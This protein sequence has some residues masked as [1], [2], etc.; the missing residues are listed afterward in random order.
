MDNP[1]DLYNSKIKRINIPLPE[2]K[3]YHR[4]SSDEKVD[5]KFIGRD[6][7]SRKLYSWLTD[8][9]TPSGSYLVTGYRGMGKSSFVGRILYELS[10]RVSSRQYWTGLFI[11]III[12][13]CL[14]LL[15]IGEDNRKVFSIFKL[16]ETDGDLWLII[17]FCIIIIVFIQNFNVVRSIFRTVSFAFRL[18]Y[19]LIWDKKFSVTQSMSFRKKIHN[20]SIVF[21][22]YF[23]DWPTLNRILHN[24]TLW[25]KT[26]RRICINV[27]LGQDTLRERE[28]LSIIAYELYK[29]YRA[30]M[31]SPIAN[32]INWFKSTAIVFGLCYF[33]YNKRIIHDLLSDIFK[34]IFN[35]FFNSS[36]FTSFRIY[37]HF[38][39][40]LGLLCI[41]YLL[42]LFISNYLPNT[43]HRALYKLNFLRDR[44]D[45]TL[46]I[47]SELGGGTNNKRYKLGYKLGRKRGFQV[48]Q[49]REIE[50]E[51]I[52]ILERISKTIFAPSFIFVFDELDK[53]E[54]DFSHKETSVPEFSNERSFP[55]GGTSRLRKR[56]VLHLLAN[57]KLFVSTAKAKFIFISGRELYDAYLADLSDRE[58]SISSIFNGVIYVDSFCTNERR[59][60]GI[61]SNTETYISKQLI[62][63]Y[64]IRKKLIHEYLGSKIKRRRFDGLDISLKMYYEYLIYIYS[65]CLGKNE[66][67]PILIYDD[68]EDNESVI[69]SEIRACIDKTIVFLYHFSVYLYHISNGSPKKMTLYFEKYIRSS[70]SMSIHH[71]LT[72]HTFLT[73]SILSNH[74][75]N[76]FIDK[77]TD[78]CLS[79]GYMDQRCIGFIHYISYPITQ[80]IISANQFGDK[81]LVSAS[82]L[83][84]HIYKY[85]NGG[86][87]WRNLEHTP[88]LLEVYRIPE[89]RSFINAI[90]SYLTQTHLIPITC[91]LYQFK[92]R[93]RIAEEISLA[94]KFSEEIAA[95]FNFTLDESLTVKQH[96]FELQQHYNEKLRQEKTLS[97]HEKVGIHHILA[98]LYMSDEEFT[99]AILEYQTA[100]K[101]ILDE[102]SINSEEQDKEKRF[103][104]YILLL[105]RNMLKL[106]LAFE[107][108]RTFESA[109]VT[110]NELI[111]R[112]IGFRHLNEDEFELQYVIRR[113]N[114]DWPN[115]EAIL[116]YK[117]KNK[118]SDLSQELKKIR[119]KIDENVSENEG[120]KIYN[121]SGQDFVSDFSH[122][123]TS[124]KDA[125]IRRLSML[126]DIR[127]VYQALLAK[128]FV[129]EKMELAGITRTNLE[130]IESEYTYL[131]LTTNDKDKFLISTDFFRRLGDI[132]FYKN[133]LSGSDVDTFTEGLYYWAFNTRTEVLDF[134][135]QNDCYHL[136]NVLHSI[137]TGIK[138]DMIP[139]NG[140]NNRKFSMLLKISVLKVLSNT[141]N[142]E[143]K[144]KIALFEETVNK[145][146]KCIPLEKVRI[147]NEH[148][149][150][151]WIKNRSL[152]CYACKYYNRSIRVLL[153]NL[154]G[155]DMMENSDKYRNSKTMIL[156]ELIIQTAT[157][158]SL[159]QNY[160]LQVAEDLD[161]LGNVTLCCLDKEDNR[162]S[163]VFLNAF[164]CDML[165]TN[166]EKPNNNINNYKLYKLY[167]NPSKK[168]LT[169]LEKVILYYWEA[170]MGFRFANDSMKASGS[171][172]KIL[173]TIQNYLKTS[174]FDSVLDRDDGR[175]IIGE[176]INE[177]KNR[178][179]KQ[180][181]ILL[182]EHYNFINIIEIQ[183]LK[184]VFSVQM[185]EHISLN[186][187]SLFPDVEEIMIIYYD[188]I[189]YCI[190]DAGICNIELE[191]KGDNSWKNL[192][193]RNHDFTIR[194][195]GFYQNIALSSLRIES[196]IYERILMWRFKADMN[197]QILHH[198]FSSTDVKVD[199]FYYKKDFMIHFTRFINVLL[200]NNKSLRQLLGD[201]NH[202]F[203]KLTQTPDSNYTKMMFLEF[204]IKDSIYCLTRILEIITPYTA[205]TLFTNSFLG[206]T[207]QMLFCWNQLF[208]ALFMTYK[209]IEE[210]EKSKKTPIDSSNNICPHYQ[211]S[212]C[213]YCDFHA[214]DLP[215]EEAF[216]IKKSKCP[217]Y[218]I[219]CCYKSSLF[220]EQMKLMS[221]YNI[222]KEQLKIYQKFKNDYLADCFFNDV[223][224]EIGRSQIH[225]TLSNYS[226]EMAMKSYR[227]TFEMHR[228]GKA[229]KSMVQKLYY[230]DDD[231]KNDTIQFDST[232]ERY[233]INNDYIL[234]N[235]ELVRSYF[236]MASIYDIENFGTD[237]ETLLPIDEKRFC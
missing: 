217:Y 93:K 70:R 148:R 141:K 159:R 133:G 137:L 98:D 5:K 111:S 158:K 19:T 76:M 156:L 117:N 62:P 30:Y 85:H 187:L 179:I 150:E 144:V 102:I 128:L 123:M 81:L 4:A 69:K 95:L 176:Y 160:I 52:E 17:F 46:E 155:V 3:I 153:K 192:K 50:Q 91:G 31:E 209:V 67:S 55:G 66:L 235:K 13:I 63:K 12:W 110:Y 54:T 186:R 174:V 214:K 129:L 2:Y 116:Y 104:T 59:E 112:L 205:T 47:D 10:A 127:L 84:D 135:N 72:N 231:L 171:L 79:F 185:Y 14:S 233:K 177:I 27:N 21:K 201:F 74:N 71:K 34:K 11:F 131:H 139:C 33:L 170:S 124:E 184:W 125:I 38:I 236:R 146:L 152:P 183:K 126:E 199:N 194:L 15:I 87:S 60:K 173:R 56:N 18:F 232:I 134:C 45:S 172:K 108:R 68:T 99:K 58:F 140:F 8:K 132:M 109:Y 178:I 37:E 103:V 162:I 191:L 28:V 206:E 36:N 107:K 96:Y 203:P 120:Y 167:K 200:T 229:Y 136:K 35:I 77:K 40:Y 118:E 154:Y 32:C 223:L 197:R 138:N 101:I 227:Q 106:G 202:C 44:L 24:V 213:P 22:T 51:M 147:C 219:S 208:D 25:K 216:K 211:N 222:L 57:M 78:Y 226:A 43:Q 204:I 210:E 48:A 83:I 39:I 80:I 166:K 64:F 49:V 122:Q 164:L 196:S 228:E 114:D 189:R 163:E 16:I 92:F 89:F 218:A 82:F 230:L 100:V 65:N 115:N 168:Q 165:E 90:I 9:S 88:E 41:I 105:I 7:L 180:C 195:T 220:D 149:R 224:R 215:N 193:E 234:R 181:L 42:Y 75:I 121:I 175:I 157:S 207:Y 212:E 97:P 73:N 20:I 26:Y 6:N 53:I 169:K 61:M 198:L 151:L 23:E 29:K 130:M 161:C 221:D 113:S 237:N 182:Y 1:F 94:S 225:Y 143:D 188:L 86:F 145:H 142:Q 119:P 190:I